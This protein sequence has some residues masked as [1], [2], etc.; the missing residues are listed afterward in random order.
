VR[1]KKRAPPRNR[2][3]SS[4]QMLTAPSLHTTTN[5]CTFSP[6]LLGIRKRARKRCTIAAAPSMHKNATSS[7]QTAAHYYVLLH[8]HSTQLQTTTHSL[9]LC[10]SYTHQPYNR[11]DATATT[12]YYPI[13]SFALSVYFHL[14][15]FL[16]CALSL[17]FSLPPTHIPPYNGEGA[18][19]TQHATTPHTLS[20]RLHTSAFSLSHTHTH[21]PSLRRRRHHCE[22]TLLL[23]YSLHTAAHQS[24]PSLSLSHAPTPTL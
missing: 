1:E 24:A 11:A 2:K 4:K 19:A 3:L 5:Y 16:A 15:F 12:R 13:L 10:L 22:T 7:L 17:L 6:H 21:T 23:A 14:H 8:P 20:T 9:A 18:I